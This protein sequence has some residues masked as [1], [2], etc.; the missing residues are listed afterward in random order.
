MRVDALRVFNDD[1]IVPVPRGRSTRTR[2]S[3]P[4]S[5]VVEGHFLH[6]DSLGN[7]GHPEPVRQIMTFSHRG[8]PHSEK[9]QTAG[10]TL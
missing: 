4:H 8:D 3:G 7:N 2:T 10:A 9:T 1:R 6:A 5:Y